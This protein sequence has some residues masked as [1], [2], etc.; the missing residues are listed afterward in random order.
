MANYNEI[1]IA[2]VKGNMQAEPRVFAHH[3]R[4]LDLSNLTKSSDSIG[5]LN[6]DANTNPQAG[7]TTNVLQRGACLYV[8]TGGNVKVRMESQ[9]LKDP[10]VEVTFYNVQSG[11]FLPIQV[12]K[13]F[14]P[15]EV[16]PNTGQPLTT[17]GTTASDIIAL[18]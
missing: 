12:L 7:D 9:Y 14:G 3:A 16:D 18:F 11:S 6:F 8:G 4:E 10:K 2:G 17:D 13:V 5:V 15:N 1:D